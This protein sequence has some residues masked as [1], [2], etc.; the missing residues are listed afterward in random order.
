MILDVIVGLNTVMKQS[1]ICYRLFWCILLVIYTPPELIAVA[2]VVLVIVVVV[3]AYYSI[4]TTQNAK[5]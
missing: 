2:V 5:Q 4:C 1:I 3:V